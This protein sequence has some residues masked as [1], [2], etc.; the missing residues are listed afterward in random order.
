MFP[1]KN[2]VGTWKFDAGKLRHVLIQLSPL[3]SPDETR[4]I[5]QGVYFTAKKTSLTLVA[6]NGRALSLVTIDN[7]GPEATAILPADFVRQAIKALDDETSMTLSL[8]ENSVKLAGENFALTS[9]LIEGNYPSYKQ[10]IPTEFKGFVMLPR[11]EFLSVVNRVSAV[12]LDQNKERWIN[13]VGTKNN[14]DL[15]ASNAENAGHESLGVKLDVPFN[16][17]LNRVFIDAVLRNLAED[18]VRLEYEDDL[19]PFVFKAGNVTSVVMGAR[20]K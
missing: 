15:S 4:H 13:I 16:A 3:Q 14:L 17:R 10:I 19:R 12:G 6:T 9:K 5:L 18:E 7:E 11:E 2:Q 8:A 1:D 20:V